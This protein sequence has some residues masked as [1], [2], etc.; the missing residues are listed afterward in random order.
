M[1]IEHKIILDV[2]EYSYGEELGKYI[3]TQK[4]A[5]KLYEELKTILG[6]QMD[7]M[8]YVGGGITIPNINYP[9]YPDVYYKNSNFNTSLA[10]ESIADK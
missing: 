6:K 4:D 7:Y 2:S 9:T 10:G 3:L 8:P 5:E 1:A